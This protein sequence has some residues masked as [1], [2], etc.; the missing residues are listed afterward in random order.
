MCGKV[1]RF[2]ISS[3]RLKDV[4]SSMIQEEVQS[5]ALVVAF[6]SSSLLI[7]GAFIGFIGDLDR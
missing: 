2:R 7:Q 3:T 6:V 1:L 4:I 5:L